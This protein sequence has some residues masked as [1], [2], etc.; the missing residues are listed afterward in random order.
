MDPW[1]DENDP[2]GAQRRGQRIEAEARQ[3]ELDWP[4]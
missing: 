2:T 4:E 1:D 3:S